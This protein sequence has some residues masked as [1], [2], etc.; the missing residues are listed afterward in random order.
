MRTFK[1]TFCIA[2]S[3][4]SCWI[5]HYIRADLIFNIYNNVNPAMFALKS[6]PDPL[7][8]GL[9]SFTFRKSSQ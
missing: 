8:L 5:F 7:N 1:K 2:K 4:I 9:F 3:L 6:A